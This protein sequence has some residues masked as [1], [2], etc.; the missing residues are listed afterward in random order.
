MTNA[1][2]HRPPSS[3]SA[4]RAMLS[5]TPPHP[6]TP[7]ATTTAT[8][9][10][11]S[12]STSTSTSS[13]SNEDLDDDL[14]FSAQLQAADAALHAATTKLSHFHR[15]VRPDLLK[16]LHSPS[17]HAHHSVTDTLLSDVP[18]P[19]YL[20]F[21]R[22]SRLRAPTSHTHSPKPLSVTFDPHTYQR[23]VIERPQ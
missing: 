19:P 14:S 15:H 18:P 5:S 4:V 8:T 16:L 13:S 17:V 3:A 9:D 12:T 10:T 22:Y 6:T 2:P 11:S 23:Y 20:H 7:N 1:S 21:Q